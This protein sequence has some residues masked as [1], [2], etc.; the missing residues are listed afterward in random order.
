MMAIRARKFPTR[1]H[2]IHVMWLSRC[3][4]AVWLIG[5]VLIFLSWFRVVDSQIG[6]IG[7]WI[8]LAAS[9]ISR[10]RIGGETKYSRLQQE[11]D[12]LDRVIAAGEGKLPENLLER[13]LAKYEAR[14]FEDAM[15]DIDAALD[16]GFEPASFAL[17]H[18]GCV[19]HH[20]RRNEEAIADFTEAIRLGPEDRHFEHIY[21]WRAD[22][23]LHQ[24]QYQQAISDY[25][26][27]LRL[28]P[29][30]AE[31]LGARG[32][33]RQLTG[34]YSGAI[35]DFEHAMQL[36]PQNSQANNG[37]AV[38]LAGCP[39]AD[40][41]DGPKAVEHATRACEASSWRD[42]RTLSVLAAAYAEAGDFHRAVRYARKALRLAP[43]E[44]QDKRQSRLAQFL[45]YEP[46]RTSVEESQI[47]YQMRLNLQ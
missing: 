2:R 24:A 25:D 3:Y 40:L 6:W 7:F 15:I 43:V 5:T 35:D 30:S 9:M 14:R 46:Y 44:E 36:D 38:I 1:T 4:K 33:A 17:F 20:L 26:D 12:Q 23:Y 29:A 19:N 32:T 16:K 27:G 31:L 11:I 47:D 18:R 28:C 39:L 42:W 22:A 45:R 10:V 13:G 34:D 37:I 41:R 8:A 21:Y